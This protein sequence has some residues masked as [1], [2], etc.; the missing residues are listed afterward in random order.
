MTKKI[1]II[2]FGN[3]GMV[4]G[5]RLKQHPDFYEV[6]VYDQDS[7]KTDQISGIHV[8]SSVT[9]LAG[10][11]AALI[12]AVKPQDF[13]TL[14][15]E[16]KEHT[17]NALVISIAAGLRMDYIE[18][19]LGEARVVRV[20]P[21]MPARIGKGISCLCKGKRA[22]A[23]DLSFATQLFSHLGKTMVIPEY[24]MNSA[25]AI[26]GSGPGYFYD[27]L[28][29]ENIDIKK[30]DV[31]EHFG[32]EVFFPRLLEAAQSIGFNPEQAEELSR[33]TV[34]GSL[35]MLA[36]TGLFPQ[37]LLAQIVSKGGTTEAALKV[38]HRGEGLKDAVEAARMR[39]EE[40]SRRIDHSEAEEN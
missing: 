36:V 15:K 16:I 18:R 8:A 33:A 12:L 34:E 7:K 22:N 5:E 14:L 31:V 21:N 9:G 3:M 20:M 30:M 37:E 32:R 19:L 39:A 40:L 28:S 35:A 25:T 11:V 4:I 13:E 27:L 6:H 24:M 17:Q 26:S 2:G 23:D 1:G 10:Q 29:K 38:L